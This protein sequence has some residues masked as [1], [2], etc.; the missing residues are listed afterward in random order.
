MAACRSV[1]L[2]QP[3]LPSVFGVY[4]FAS[5]DAY[6]TV[7]HTSDSKASPVNDDERDA[8][9]REIR[10]EVRLTNGR[11]GKLESFRTVI[12]REMYGDARTKTRGLIERSRGWDDTR[13]SVDAMT[14]WLKRTAG[15][16]L[17]AAFAL[18]VNLLTDAI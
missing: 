11:V 5:T 3:A 18:G 4:T 12:E 9:L 10:D 17:T 6:T 7:R 13:R 16:L 15:A 2:A 14:L 8:M 1:A